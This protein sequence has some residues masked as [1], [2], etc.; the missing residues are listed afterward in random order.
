VNKDDYF[1]VANDQYKVKLFN[2]TTH[3][4]RRTNLAPI[5]PS[6]TPSQHPLGP[7][8]NHLEVL[9]TEQSLLKGKFVVC[10]NTGGIVGVGKLP[11]DGNPYRSMAIIAHAGGVSSICSSPEGDYIFTAGK[12]DSTINVWKVRPEMIEAQI[13]LTG[14]ENAMEPFLELLPDNGGRNGAFYREMEDFF[15]Y[16]QLQTQGEDVTESRIIHRRVDMD[17]V[18]SAMRALGFYPSQKQIDDILNEIK[19][20]QAAET[21]ELNSTISFDELLRRKCLWCSSDRT[22]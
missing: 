14:G 21:G 8:I 16:A 20:W 3:N 13:S 15:Y 6:P 5:F 22:L 9:G 19:F 7:P 10:G 4:C 17:Q 2:S 11:F 1:L 18:P 12:S